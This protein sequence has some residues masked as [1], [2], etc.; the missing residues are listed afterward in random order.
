MAE[1]TGQAVRSDSAD[2]A[3]WK[4]TLEPS[5][6]RSRFESHRAAKKQNR[7]QRVLDNESVISGLQ[8]GE[9]VVTNGQLLLADG[10][11]V[12]IRE[13]KTGS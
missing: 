11:K 9:T 12:E 5:N 4:L 10:T 1:L 2:F 6:G 8:G 13:P 3:R 7:F